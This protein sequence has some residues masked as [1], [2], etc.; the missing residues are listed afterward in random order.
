LP[1]RNGGRK[2][3]VSIYGGREPTNF[4]AYCNH[5]I[6]HTNG[7]FDC[8]KAGGCWQSRVHPMQKNADTNKRMCRHTVS[9]DGR[10]IQECMESISSDDVIRAISKYYE[11]N[12]Y[13]LSPAKVGKFVPFRWPK[14]IPVILDDMPACA[15]DSSG[16][17]INVLA[18]LSSKGGGEQ[19]ICKIVELLRG[20]GWKVNFHPWESIH[21][22]YQDIELVHH[23]F[24]GNMEAHMKSGLPLLF[25]AN[26]QI[27]KFVDEGQGIVDKSSALIVGINYINSKLPKSQWLAKT[28]K[29]KAVIFQ[30]NEK[31]AE[32]ERDQ[33]GFDNTKLIT[34]FGAIDL[35]KYLEVCPR[36]RKKGEPLVILKH[37]L[38][39][40]RKYVTKESES[41]GEKIHLWQKNII[42]E[43]DVKFYGRLLKSIKNIRFEFMEAHK[44][45]IEEFK[46]EPRMVFHKWNAMD[47]GDFLGCGHIYLYRTSNKWRDQYPR[48]VA[49]AL[50][51][52]LPVLSEPRDGTK[53]RQDFGNIG[54]SCIDFDGF[55]YAIRLLQRKENYRHHM[56]MRAKDWARVNLDPRRWVSVI[57]EIILDGT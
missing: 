39:D 48:V 21:D 31:R 19:S 52:G 37:C 24:I 56:G 16:K 32:F 43:R 44:E 1:S 47:V 7:A 12:L 53:D 18:S 50:A 4:T 41:G 51:A 2:P 57:E 45:L 42:K 28:G 30:N 11:G 13:S 38:G 46:D 29:L 25:Y 55:L 10:T 23:S 5:Q 15:F 3:C 34:L 27:G 6:L 36:E 9:V 49:E 20:S 22:N 35:N 17:E 54:F 40:Y 14:D 26:D 8:C 33:I